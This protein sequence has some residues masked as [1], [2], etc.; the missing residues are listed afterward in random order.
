MMSKKVENSKELEKRAL[1]YMAQE[2]HK[3]A[4]KYAE[5]LKK[6]CGKKFEDWI[7]QAVIENDSFED[8]I[9]NIKRDGF[10]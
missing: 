5:R 2:H 8:F 7:W 1:F 10:K 6:L 3:E 4:D 9:E